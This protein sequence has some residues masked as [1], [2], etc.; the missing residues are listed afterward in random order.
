M[1]DQDLISETFLPASG[2][3]FR[4]IAEHRAG[5]LIILPSGPGRRICYGVKVEGVDGGEG[6]GE[7]AVLV[8]A[9]SPWA[10]EADCTGE[11]LLVTGGRTGWLGSAVLGAHYDN[12]VEF[13]LEERASPTEARSWGSERGAL[14]L[15][16]SGSRIV[17]GAA[18]GTDLWGAAVDPTTWRLDQTAQ[19]DEQQVWLRQWTWV[20][21]T[22]PGRDTR[23]TVRAGAAA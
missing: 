19:A 4:P 12:R 15:G 8:L 14:A 7:H 9:G 10:E 11:V 23:I 22:R 13:S 1:N 5:S 17:V 2:L 6:R 18:T 21:Q 3:R 20:L 16:G